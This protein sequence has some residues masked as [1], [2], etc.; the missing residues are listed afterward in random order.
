VFKAKRVASDLSLLVYGAILLSVGVAM[1]D[2]KKELLRYKVAETRLS[3]IELL[4][5][6]DS[7]QKFELKTQR[8]NRF[9]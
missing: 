9:F 6:W 3:Q 1:V 7:V 4:K 2:I 8:T 5:I